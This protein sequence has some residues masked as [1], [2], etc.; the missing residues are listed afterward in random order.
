M[1]KM[2]ATRALVAIS[3]LMLLITPLAPGLSHALAAGDG[4]PD[5]A[6]T[7]DAPGTPG[8]HQ[9]TAPT[10]TAAPKAPAPRPA[11]G[12]LAMPGEGMLLRA[13]AGWRA[14]VTAEALK[15][16][17][18][19]YVWG[20]ASPAGWDCSGFVQWVFRTAAG[21]ELPRTAGV[22]AGVGVL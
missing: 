7:A 1:M 21:V 15:H 19:P 10:P 14:A 6:D 11:A 8:V 13:P 17:G 12:P 22:Q 5:P 18:V 9:P 20:G 4:A 3:L 16:Q 2:Q